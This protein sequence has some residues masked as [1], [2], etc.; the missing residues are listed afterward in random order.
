MSRPVL[1]LYRT[2]AFTINKATDAEV[3]AADR[4]EQ[5]RLLAHILYTSIPSAVV[6]SAIQLLQ[7]KKNQVFDIGKGW[8]R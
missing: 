1:Y 2:T 4:D 6:D 7:H 3:M 5:A 8:S